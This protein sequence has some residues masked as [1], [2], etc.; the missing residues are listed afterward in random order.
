MTTTL[1][2]HLLALRN[3]EKVII[4][5]HNLSIPEVVAAGRYG[6]QVVLDDSSEVRTRITKSQQAMDSKLAA[7]KSVYGISTGFGGS[8]TY[9]F[10]APSDG[11]LLKFLASFAPTSSRY[12]DERASRSG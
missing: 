4:N 10:R 9:I 6:A 5:G 12:S 7:G 1:P 8:G 11:V 3:G 2:S